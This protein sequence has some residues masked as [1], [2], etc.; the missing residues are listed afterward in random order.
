MAAAG[1]L[2]PK[3][4]RSPSS[5]FGIIGS[6]NI[7]GRSSWVCLV[8]QEAATG[9]A[10]STG[11]A[12]GL[13]LLTLLCSRQAFQYIEVLSAEFIHDDIK[14]QNSGL[15]QIRLPHVAI[16]D[17]DGIRDIRSLPSLETR[18]GKGGTIGFLA[19]EREG[20]VGIKFSTP[21]DV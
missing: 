20:P 5:L 16:L 15:L 8:V 1:G 3:G 2:S 18:H 4:K 7:N 14:A 21:V 19:P 12:D 11:D 6:R 10:P 13:L 9:G 17:I